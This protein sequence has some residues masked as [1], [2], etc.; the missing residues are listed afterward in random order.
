MQFKKSYL[1]AAGILGVVVLYFIVRTLFG[2]G[3]SH[4]APK[5]KTGAGRPAPSV[6]VA[7]VPEQTRTYYVTMRGRTES[8]R[9][10]IVRSET[11][12]VVAQTPV[13]EGSFV[14]KGAVL[15][16]LS[17]DARQA[18]LDQARASL[19]SR[20]LQQEASVRLA[21][22][23]FR[24]QTQVLQDRANLDN[25]SAQVRQAE[26]LLEQIN[27]RAPFAG[28]FDRREAEIGTYLSPGQ[29][30]GTMIELSPILI[31]GDVPETE[32]GRLTV[33]QS[34]TARLVSGETLSGRV[35]FVARDA[36]PQTR[37]YHVEVTAPNPSMTAR[38]GLS[39]ELKVAAGSGPAHLVP[40]SAVVLDA[41]GRQGVR[42][43]AV[44]NKVAFAPITTL[45]ETPQGVWVR[46]LS[47]A[48]Q[49]ITVG[50][51]Y[52]S[53]GQAVRVAGK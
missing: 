21:E 9:T 2:G 36:D 35:R 6:Q 43:L 37:T 5:G 28:V 27:I 8:A 33:G 34:A 20:E 19:R 39:A 32:A 48:V 29:P 15:C 30:C 18:S 41:D 26:I 14:R 13:V 3:E 53:E 10:V 7:V 51:S 49:V 52:V 11:A 25:A 16:R 44:G 1:V 42:Y 38:S 50:Q 47:G 23:G 24:S 40:V 46:G 31:V 4:E 12:G 45:E 17:V 22:K